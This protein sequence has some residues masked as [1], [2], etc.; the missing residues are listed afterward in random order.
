MC[1]NIFGILVLKI[2]ILTIGPQKHEIRDLLNLSDEAS[3]G[4]LSIEENLMDKSSVYEHRLYLSQC[5]V[6]VTNDTQK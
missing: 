2:G 6:Q 4:E 1:D 3:S 5:H